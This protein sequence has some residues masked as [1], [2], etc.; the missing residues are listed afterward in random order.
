MLVIFPASLILCDFICRIKIGEVYAS[1][2]CPICNFLQPSVASSLL[3]PYN[4][5]PSAYVM[6][7]ELFEVAYSN[8]FRNLEEILSRAQGK[9]GKQY[10]V[11][12]RSIIIIN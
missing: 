3:P 10:K 12:K 11:L 5:T 8:F 6:A 2:N 1:Q 9:F 4:L 7:G